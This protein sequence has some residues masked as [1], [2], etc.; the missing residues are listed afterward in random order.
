MESG[1]GGPVW[2]LDSP[3]ARVGVIA[4]LELEAQILRR[5]LAAKGLVLMISGPGG[6]P[7][8][9]AAAAA[10][11]RGA[12]SLCAWGLAGGLA[13]EVGTGDI[14]IPDT[15]LSASGEY[16]ADPNWRERVIAAIGGSLK[17]IGGVLYTSDHV[18]TTPAAKASLRQR[19]G[20][21]AV[22]MESAA[23]AA[24]AARR[25]VP[26][27]AVRVI[28]DGPRDALPDRVEDLV[29]AAGKTR[30]A[31][32]VPMLLSPPELGRHFRLG[33]QS[34]RARQVLTRLAARLAGG[35]R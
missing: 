29:T 33:W 10:L 22:D 9:R 4:A 30:I 25:G 31:G 16:R 6:E 17:V 3:D 11:D 14:V 7:A 34:R 26:F 24:V 12:V 23:V 15:L 2:H 21:V 1:T 32:L 27:I 35:D 20:A 28:A 5:E 19:T 13:A 8:A 18:L